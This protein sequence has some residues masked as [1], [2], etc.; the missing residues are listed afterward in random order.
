M[1]ARVEIEV[2]LASARWRRAL[3][4]APRIARAAARAAIDAARG[5]GRA[6]PRR[7]ELSVVLAD[8]ALV[9]RLNSAYR[10]RDQPTNVLSFPALTRAERA[11]AARAASR[12]RS[13]AQ[14][15]DV[16]AA[17]ETSRREAAALAKPLA[18]HLAHLV[19]HGTLH[20]VGYDH[21]REREAVR[22][23]RL[24]R[25][26]LAGLGIPAAAAR[27]DSARRRPHV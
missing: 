4:D 1:R 19:V 8:D 2:S 5:E 23:E 15:G 24:E 25:R 26:I 12:P 3:R 22:M 20:L 17:F 27:A 16:V 13:P 7:A 10:H 11:R 14:L 9:R 6:L 21:K 18:H